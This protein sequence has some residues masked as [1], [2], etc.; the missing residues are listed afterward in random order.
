MI[1]FPSEFAFHRFV[2]DA[3][4]TLVALEV[5]PFHVGPPMTLDLF[6]VI[7]FPCVRSKT[8]GVRILRC[9]AVLRDVLAFHCS[10]FLVTCD[11]NDRQFSTFPP[12]LLHIDHNGDVRYR[13]SS[14]THTRIPDMDQ[15]GEGDQSELSTLR[16]ESIIKHDRGKHSSYESLELIIVSFR[17][18]GASSFLILRH[19]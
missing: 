3:E 16:S 17:L 13:V 11:G 4:K 9:R 1:F 7:E 2:Y 15:S 18:L 14:R 12:F 19:S 5:L 8:P 10:H 6:P